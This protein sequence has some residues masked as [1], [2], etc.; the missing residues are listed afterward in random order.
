VD[1]GLSA[2]GWGFPTCEWRQPG[3]KK[4]LAAVGQVS[5]FWLRPSLC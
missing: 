3:F 5:Y 4:V 1:A 2:M